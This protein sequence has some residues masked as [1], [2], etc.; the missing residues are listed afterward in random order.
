MNWLFFALLA[1]AIYAV[2]VSID[3]Y[4]LEK[5]IKDYQAMPIY[6]A[7]MATIF[8][9]L[10]WVI[11]G[12]PLLN[13]KDTLLILL[14]GI[15]ISWGGA[16]YF[17]AL[18]NNQV[19]KVTFLLQMTPPITLILSFLL[20][21]DKVSLQKLLGFLLILT[22]TL[23][24]SNEKKI[25][26]F[27]FSNSFFLILL[28]DFLWSFS[29]IIFKFAVDADSFVK[30]FSYESWGIGLGGLALYKLFP[31][32]RLAFQK[33]S[34]KINR[35]IL[36]IVAF[37]EGLYLIGKFFTYFAIVLGPVALVDVVG[38]TQVLFAVVYGW[39]LTLL[40]PKIFKENISTKG[41]LKSSFMALIAFIGIWLLS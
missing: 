35:K 23:I 24:I 7:I 17:K 1:P 6:T 27:K 31:S 19:S 38:G 18:S 10:I 3:K 20:L 40:A 15:L 37:N 4:L 12:S 28:A 16:L 22:A 21:G 8:G 34:K 26:K 13:L 9:S 33:T 30:V 36:S 5:E 25:S 41:L 29:Y 2:V 11:T 39:I 14:T 32:I